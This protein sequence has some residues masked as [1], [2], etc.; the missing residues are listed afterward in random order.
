V[1]PSELRF[2]PRVLNDDSSALSSILVEK[3]LDLTFL[4]KSHLERSLSRC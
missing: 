4:E 3:M 2:Q 1:L